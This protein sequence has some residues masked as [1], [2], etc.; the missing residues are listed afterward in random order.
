MVRMVCILEWVGPGITNISLACSL[1]VPFVVA[2]T[3]VR[4][5]HLDMA[6]A[7]VRRDFA[8]QS[9]RGLEA[10]KCQPRPVV[11]IL[12]DASAGTRTFLDIPT[13]RAPPRPVIGITGYGLLIFG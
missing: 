6:M 8:Y 5:L 13:E 4:R 9:K 12:S 7:A 11:V 3:G 10:G 2:A 1:R